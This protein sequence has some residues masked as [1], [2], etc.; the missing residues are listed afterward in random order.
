MGQSVQINKPYVE[1]KVNGLEASAVQADLVLTAGAPAGATIGF[2]KQSEQ[3]AQKAMVSEVLS[4][5]VTDGMA[6]LQGLNFALRSTPDSSVILSRDEETKVELEGYCTGPSYG[7]MSG[8]VTRGVTIASQ[9]ALLDRLSMGIYRYD[10]ADFAETDKLTS[11]DSWA[12][13]IKQATEFLVKTGQVHFQDY[14][15]GDRERVLQKHAGNVAMGLPIW[16]KLLDDS[17]ETTKSEALGN[18]DKGTDAD[19]SI[20][21]GIANALI[22]V[23]SQPVQRF[24]NV[25][26][27][28]CAMFQ[29]VYIPTADKGSVGYLMKLSDVTRAEPTKVPVSIV[30]ID[31]SSAT[32][33]LLPLQQ[34]FALNASIAQWPPP[35]ETTRPE[36]IAG[37]PETAAATGIDM[38]VPM[39]GWLIS[40]DVLGPTSKPQEIAFDKPGLDDPIDIDTY[41][42][43]VSQVVER[44][45]KAQNDSIRA[46]LQEYIQ[47]IWCDVSLASSTANFAIPL[48]PNWTAGSRYE[49]Q[50][51]ASGK[52]MFI[53]WLASVKH[54]VRI[55]GTGGR[56][57]GSAMSQLGFTHVTMGDF[58]LP[59]A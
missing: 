22:G 42:S 12:A 58:T 59:G 48:N 23:L 7:L 17:V 32:A 55:G 8:G 56:G 3:G 18:L 26:E 27:Q 11:G 21:N 31:M 38:D 41:A 15:A 19:V 14:S 46:L 49:I 45:R 9:I 52:T 53:G 20:N 44:S 33:S 34:V 10:H 30:S 54:S 25:L 28:L 39:P 6:A 5:D 43:G 35:P 40:G 50:D 4:T 51:P 57:E 16:Y 47:N 36:V 24:W 37:W 29:L 2:H 13:R 1:L